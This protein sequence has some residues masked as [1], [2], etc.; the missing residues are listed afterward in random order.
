VAKSSP[1]WLS[2]LSFLVTLAIS[3]IF[4]LIILGTSTD[5]GF[6]AGAALAICAV[7]SVVAIVFFC[8]SFVGLLF[9]IKSC[10]QK[11]GK[12]VFRI[13]GLLSNGALLI[14]SLKAAYETSP[15]TLLLFIIPIYY[16]GKVACD[17]SIDT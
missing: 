9:G 2:N 7:F 6:S 1:N 17:K 4:Y 8:G 12:L 10:K 3:V 13:T 14:I 16:L 11:E 5:D 15:I